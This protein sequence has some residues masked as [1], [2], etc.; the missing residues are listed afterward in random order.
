MDAV[1]FNYSNSRAAKARLAKLFTKPLQASLLAIIVLL[2]IAGA[3]LLFMG[4]AFGW[5][6]A[7][8]AGNT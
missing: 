5:F 1:V 4:I 7:S 2:V 6:I 8:K 3:A